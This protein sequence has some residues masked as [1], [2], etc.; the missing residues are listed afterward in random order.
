MELKFQSISA[1]R[2]RNSVFILDARLCLS[3]YLDQLIDQL[4]LRID[5]L[6]TRM[7]AGTSSLNPYAEAYIPLS[8]RG[9]ADGIK[10]VESVG[11]E[12]RDS[13]EVSFSVG[14]HHWDPTAQVPQGYNSHGANALYSAENSKLKGHVVQGFQSSSSFNPSELEKAI[15]D[16]ELDLDLAYLQT[17]FPGISDESLSDVY[18]ANK[19]DVDATVEML[20]HLES[21]S[22]SSEKLPE[23]LDIGDVP[24]PGV[25]IELPSQEAGPS[26]SGVSG[27]T[28]VI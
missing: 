2:S 12:K 26:S 21:C 27:S 4:Q 15:L 13:K 17:L 9:A 3:F 18:F 16:E 11:N 14:L 20:N 25:G 22:D 19:G 7:K 6:R 10:R 5:L 24:E 8:K 23:T 28:V 1:S